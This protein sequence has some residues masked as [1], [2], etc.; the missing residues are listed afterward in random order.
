MRSPPWPALSR[1]RRWRRGW[2][3][4]LLVALFALVRWSK[5][6]GFA[7]AYAVLT[8]PFWPGSAQREWIQSGVEL[9]QQSKLR[10]L[11]KDN[12]R[13]RDLLDLVQS[14]SGVD[15]LSAAVISRTPQGWWQQLELGKGRLHGIQPGDA[16]LGPGGLL[17]RI[18]SVTPITSRV[19]LLTSPGSQVGVWIP[20]TQRHG[21]LIGMGSR[22]PQMH[23]LDKDPQVFAGDVV[24]ISPSSSLMPANVPVGVIQS[25][26]YHALPAPRAA[27]QLI[28][29]P[30]AIDWVQ[31]QIRS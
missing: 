2:L 30:E 7:D 18:Q 22:R 17:G 1:W 9:E 21:L 4:L 3:W 6:A 29:A 11:E 27:V 19:R 28:A 12:Q 23:F 25:V 15:E 26:D 10:W 24:S 8:R 5:G 31:V 13:L 16:V 20:R 14:S